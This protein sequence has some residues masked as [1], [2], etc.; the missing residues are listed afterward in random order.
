MVRARFEVEPQPRRGLQCVN[1]DRVRSL[2]QSAGCAPPS[3]ASS[4][5]ARWICCARSCCSAAPTGSTGSCAARCTARRRWPSRT[6]ASIV[7]LERSLHVFVE[8]DVQPGRS[9]TGW[10]TNVTSWMYINR[11][12][13][14]PPCTLA[15]I[16]L[17][18]NEH[19]YFVRNMY[20][21]AMGLALVGYVAYPTAPPRMFPELGFTDSVAEFT[22]VSD[23]VGQRAVQPVRGGAVDA[24]LLRA[25]DRLCRWSGS[26]AGAGCARSGRSIRP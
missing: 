17:R 23:I 12:S 20:M 25:D 6:R 4:P 13:S 11:T 19:F 2:L 10:L 7:H 18:R 16:Y 21:V 8:P 26:S 9:R 3:N 14:S 24:R 5:R 1:S 22:R 15:F